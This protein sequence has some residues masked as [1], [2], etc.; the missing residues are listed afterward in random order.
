M[1]ER[2]VTT[3][4]RPAVSF[5]ALSGRE[6]HP[7]LQ[8]EPQN[9]LRF[10]PFLPRSGKRLPFR[11]QKQALGLLGAFYFHYSKTCRALATKLLYLS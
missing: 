9:A 3:P 7:R 5:E 8:L 2:Q 1:A 4:G 11:V 10:M 6:S